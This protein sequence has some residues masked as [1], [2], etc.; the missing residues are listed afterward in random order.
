MKSRSSLPTSPSRSGPALASGSSRNRPGSLGKLE[1]IAVRLASIQ[2]ADRP[3][4]FGRRVVVFAANHGVTEEGV[5]PYPAEVTAQMVEELRRGR[6]GDQ[7]SCPGCAG[8]RCRPRRRSRAAA[9]RNLAREPAMSEDGDA[10][11][12]R[13]GASRSASR[14]RADSV[15]LLGLGE[16]GIGNT[17]AASAI[18]AALTGLPPS[19]VTGPGTG[20][21][22]AGRRHKVEVIERALALHGL[23]SRESARST[24]RGGRSRDRRARGA[25]P[26]SRIAADRD[27]RRW[28]H[29]FGGL[30]HRRD[31][32]RRE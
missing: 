17:T 23:P 30:R 8:E 27:R 9:R 6:R 26:R 7:R 21:D 2:R 16:M 15:A 25:M 20:L 14:A 32:S 4:S 3:V 11:R 29:R 1:S 18:A 22:E 13:D 28:L 19:R 10:R 31:S 5:S 12:H 24:S